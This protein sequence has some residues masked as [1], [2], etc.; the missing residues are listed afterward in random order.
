MAGHKPFSELMKTFMP[1]RHV[2]VASKA[3]ALRA[4]IRAPQHLPARIVS[5]VRL[6]VSWYRSDG[7]PPFI[8]DGKCVEN[9]R[10]PAL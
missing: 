3:A 4:A 8:Q 1:E 6:S 2:R 7:S 5:L 9:A 10:L